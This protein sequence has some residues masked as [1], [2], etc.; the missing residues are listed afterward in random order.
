MFNH[1]LNLLG[2]ANIDETDTFEPDILFE[3]TLD[4]DTK[5]VT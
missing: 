4:I 5:F 1:F 2:G 3:G